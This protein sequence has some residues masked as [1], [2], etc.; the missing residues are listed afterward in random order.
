MRTSLRAMWGAQPDCSR[1]FLGKEKGTRLGLQEGSPTLGPLAPD[2]LHDS[3]EADV[4]R[5]AQGL[6]ASPH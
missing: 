6:A 2:D 1:D 5:A 3:R 4:S